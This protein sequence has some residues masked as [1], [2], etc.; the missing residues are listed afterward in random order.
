MT[1]IL[2]TK[3]VGLHS[4]S[5][6][7]VMD[8]IGT[9]ADHINFAISNGMNALA[10]TDHGHMNGFSHQQAAI[11]KL[12]NK[13]IEFKGL[14][15]AEAYFIPSLEQWS[16]LKIKLAEDKRIES[17]RVAIPGDE[18]ASTEAELDEISTTN[19][20]QAGDAD[21]GGTIIENETESKSK[22]K[23][24]LRARSHLVLLAKNSAGLKGLFNIISDGSADG[25]Y[26]GFPRV[27][28]SILRK[29]AKGN[30]I[31]STA[32][33][34]GYPARLIFDLQQNDDWEAWEPNTFNFEK[35]QESLR[36]EIEKFQDILGKEN[37]F[38]ELQF[39]RIG[40]QHLLNQH[41]IEASKRTG[42]PLIVTVDAHYSNPSHWREREIYKAI[43]W[44]MKGGEMKDL[45][46]TVAELK[47]ELYPKNAQQVWDSYK[48]Y[49]SS[50]YEF[51]DDKLIKE[52]IER[53]HEI[54]FNHIGDVH[55]DKSLKLPA[56]T[57]L[58]APTEYERVEKLL[59]T[60]GKEHDEDAVCYRELRDLVVRG[61][62]NK[63]KTSKEYADRAKLELDTI[64]HLGIVKY[65]L[66][67]Y[68]I[69]RV[70][71]EQMLLGTARGSAGGSLVCYLLG[72]TQVDPLAYGLLFE[73]FLSKKKMGLPDID[74]DFAD[75]DA[76]VKLLQNYFGEENV[77][78]V[79]NFSKLQL[80]S[81]CKDLARI[82][83]VPFEL[84]NSYTGKMRAEAMAVAKQQPGFDAQTWDLT[85]EVARKDS[86]SY[87][88]FVK[89]MEKYPG[90]SDALEVLFKQ[91]KTVSKH[92]G[93]VI[94]TDNARAAMPLIKAKGGLQTPWPEGLEARHLEKYGLLKFDILGLGTLGVFEKTVERILR[95]QHPGR[96]HFLFREINKWFYDNVHADNNKMNDQHVFKHVFHEGRFS[97]IFQ[98]VK[99]NTQAFIAKMKPT[100]IEDIAVATSIFRPGP[101]GVGV[102]KMYLRN[103][104]N[105]DEIVY[106]HPLLETVLAPTSGLL[107]F[108][109]QLQLIYHK[110]AG[111]PLDE[112]DSVRKAFTKK[113]MSNKEKAAQDREKLKQEFVTKC[114]ETNKIPAHVCID[115]FEEMEKLVA[116]SFNKSHAV[117]YAI[118]AYQCA[119]FLTY[120]P[121]E[122]ICA[123]LDYCTNSKGKAAN[124]EDPTAVAMQEAKQLGYEIIKPDINYSEEEF[125]VLPGKKIVPSMSSLKYVG[126]T[127]L[128]EIKQ[129]RPYT[130]IE[131]LLINPDGSWRHSKFNKRSLE[132]LIKLGALESLNLVGEGK[133]LRT[134]RELHSVL[135]DSFDL[136]KRTS[137]R[138][139][140]NDVK[141]VLQQAI[142]DVLA[143]NIPDWTTQEKIEFEE[144]LAGIVKSTTI[145]SEESKQKLEDNGFVSIDQCGSEGSCWGVLKEAKVKLTKT[146]KLYLSLKLTGANAQDYQCF[147]W[148]WKEKTDISDLTPYS[149]IAG[150]FKRSDF[151]FTSYPGKF[152]KVNV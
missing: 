136:Y 10:L 93:G 87:N 30:I 128:H 114:F 43:G 68:N 78:P 20:Q 39:N 96:K 145:I 27:D 129:F 131:D 140:N 138:K 67:Q 123:Y 115:I 40:A 57:K 130:T 99:P 121:D 50:K 81:L 42:A 112:T 149:V 76:A 6:Y 89:E 124:G 101:L 47:C 7:S 15:G 139:K 3:F 113:D 24:P 102:D 64:K 120:Y 103:R 100:T 23:N 107:V 31:A 46:E 25:S 1:D 142:V 73:R 85:L 125:V 104:E 54:A 65:F 55:V 119:W 17:Q 13:G 84:V 37:Y 97:G 2:P 72:I 22:V 45:P 70:V 9:P 26:A 109:E 41:L 127:A 134:Y 14:A 28:Y 63:K 29:H 12:K 56:V 117:A 91:Q 82:F 35:I 118:I 21:D 48:F 11:E 144:K 86:P 4:H 150:T 108:Q 74:S 135:L 151:G 71:G 105:E 152:F 126:K 88:D 5:T 44:Q 80:A 132:T 90:F 61:M 19:K 33:L 75:R 32:C 66:T 77:I 60:E 18:L 59:V 62:I 79:S 34:A 94:I 146:S 106:K 143:K 141:P 110:L 83:N 16:E 36:Q 148:N 69:M 147:I 51:Y 98:F 122:W 53:T 49:G 95:K 92:A 8:A 52:A 137:A 116:Y 133:P 111:V 38:L 58:V